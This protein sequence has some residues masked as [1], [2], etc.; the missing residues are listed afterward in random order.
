MQFTP[1]LCED[2]IYVVDKTVNSATAAR[3]VLK[4]FQ[5]PVNSEAISDV[6]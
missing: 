6:T 2:T 5:T 4:R 1:A 3:S